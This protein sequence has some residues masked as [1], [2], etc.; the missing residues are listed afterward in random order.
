MTV[1]HM[2]EA[3]EQRGRTGRLRAANALRKDG[4]RVVASRSNAAGVIDGDR[5][6]IAGIAIR[7]HEGKHGRSAGPGKAAGTADGLGEDAI[8]PDAVGG[9]VTSIGYV[10]GSTIAAAAAIACYGEQ[11]HKGWNRKI[12]FGRCNGDWYG[13]TGR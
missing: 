6:A 3:R 9:D 12:E 13:L 2:T 11:S 8:G 10:D 5:A 4:A 7:S 1:K